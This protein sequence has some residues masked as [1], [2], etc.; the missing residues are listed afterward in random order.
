[1]YAYFDLI[2]LCKLI[3]NL[4]MFAFEVVISCSLSHSLDVGLWANVVAGIEPEMD[5]RKQSF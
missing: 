5:D 2:D 4:N 1:M 3:F